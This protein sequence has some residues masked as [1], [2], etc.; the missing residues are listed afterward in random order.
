MP[1]S[2]VLIEMSLALNVSIDYFF[3]KDEVVIND[4][5]FR[6]R[7]AL[8]KG[9]ETSI[10]EKVKDMAEKYF[11][12]ENILDCGRNNIPQKEFPVQSS[13]DASEVARK[14]KEYWKIGRDGISN[15][16]E[17]LEDNGA[18]VI[19]V[20]ADRHFDGLSGTANGRVIIVVSKDSNAE[21][22]RFTILHELGH[23][24]MDTPPDMPAEEVESL[25]NTFASEMLIDKEDFLLKI[26]SER[27]DIS[28]AELQDLQRHYGISIDAL[29]SKAHN[30]KVITDSRYKFYHIKKNKYKDFGQAVVS[31]L[32]NQESSHRFE[33]LVYKALACE[34][35]TE[36]K[37]VDLLN[38]SVRDVRQSL[39]LI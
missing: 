8:P 39:S 37:A 24:V 11:E 29:M 9:L 36:S 3:R 25:C 33:R 23:V 18:M 17:T 14:V 13:E 15:V 5:E 27:K 32:C 6:K 22:K 20:E 12:I 28:L 35:I 2:D 34:S 19:E 21:R 1:K 10:T 16:I 7:K 26:G 31:S 38:V 30:L 4:I